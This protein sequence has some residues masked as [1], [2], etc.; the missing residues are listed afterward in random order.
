MSPL[1]KYHRE[2]VN[3]SERYELFVNYHELCNAYTELNDPF[4]QRELFSD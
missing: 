3:I 2:H 1:A 4:I